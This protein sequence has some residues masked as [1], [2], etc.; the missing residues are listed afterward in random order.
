MYFLIYSQKLEEQLENRRSQMNDIIR[1][2]EEMM[3]TA[4]PEERAKLSAQIKDVKASFDKIRAKCDRKSKRL[5]DALK[6]VS[7]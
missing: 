2:A 5:E 1:T 4:A 3:E 7:D 6:E